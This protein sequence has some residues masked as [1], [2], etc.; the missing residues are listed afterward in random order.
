MI[1]L[2]ILWFISGAQTAGRMAIG[3]NYFVEFAPVS[4]HDYMGTIWNMS[5]GFIYIYITIYYRLISKKWAPV[6]VFA[7][8]LNIIVLGFVLFVLPESPKWLYNKK[9]FQQFNKALDQMAK[10]NGKNMVSTK[11]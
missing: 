5:E 1:V 10:F 9:K 4:A 7:L 11:L 6:F 8:I 3:Y 2:I